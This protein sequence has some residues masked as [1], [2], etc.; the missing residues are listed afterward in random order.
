VVVL[1]VDDAGFMDFGGYGGEAATPNINRIADEGVRFTNYHTSPLCAPSRAML[2]TGLDNHKTGIATIPEVLTDEQ[3]NEPGY[4]MHFLPGV[5]TIADYLKQAGY[6]TFMTGKWHLGSGENQLPNAHGFDRSFALDASGADNWE[7]KPFMPFYEDAPWFEDGDPALLPKDFYSSRFLVD[8]MIE[9]LND[10]NDEK[11]FFSYIAFQA[12]HIPVQAPR[13]FT[14]HY[15]GI[16]TD[17][18]NAILERRFERA[19][20]LDLVPAEAQMPDLHPSLRDWET[21]SPQEKE[22][23]E[24]SMMVNAGMLEAMDHHI[25]RLVTYLKLAGELDNTVFVITSDNGPEF[26]DPA[27]NA[28]FRFW[29][30]Q[31][32]YDENIETLGEKGSMG[33]IGPEWASTASVPGSLFKFYASEGGTRVPLIM[34]GPGIKVRGFNSS[35][36]FV[37]DIT[38]TL[39]DITGTDRKNAWDGKS[40][41][42]ILRGEANQTYG[43]DEPVGLEVAGNAALF[44]GKY[45]L[46]RNTLPH[47]DGKWRLHDVLSDP[48]EIEDLSNVHPELRENMLVDYD[49]FTKKM[50][51]IAVPDNFNVV[52]QVSSNVVKKVIESNLIWLIIAGS[53]ILI[54]LAGLGNL[55]YRKS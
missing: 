27:R 18:W 49:E 7:Q 15:E 30:S 13:E 12:I 50:N 51:V 24:R 20:E 14:N 48:A 29:M 43:I 52:D 6:E 10:R 31:N 11:P 55:L 22:H 47:G 3:K 17:G 25:G 8:K 32:G 45:K 16:Y 53:L 28:G 36:N 9:Y 41:L 37:M 33:A 26:N 42:P 23:Y 35:L 54:F 21:L 4:A 34:A 19:K 2:L 46:T 5:L 40:L 1:L 44:K 39:V 38:P